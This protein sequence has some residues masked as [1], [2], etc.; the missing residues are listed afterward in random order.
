MSNT[1]N[2]CKAMT[3][4]Q[5]LRATSKRKRASRWK[6]GKRRKLHRPVFFGDEGEFLRKYEIDAFHPELG[7]ALEVE[8]SPTGYLT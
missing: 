5:Q 3:C 6:P 2:A 8:S 7:V 4:C 1:S